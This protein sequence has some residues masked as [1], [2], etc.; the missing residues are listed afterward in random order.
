MSRSQSVAADVSDRAKPVSRSRKSAAK[1]DQIIQAAIVII[2]K[3]SYALATMAEIA[4]ALDLQDAALYHYFPSKRSLAYACHRHSLQRFERIL[5]EADA[6]DENGLGK[7]R[8]F[9]HGFL[10]DS[11]RH[12][13]QLYFGDYSYLDATQRR[14]IA[15]WAERLKRALEAFLEEGMA[16]G[17]ISPCESQLV[18]QFIVG[19]LIWMGKWVPDVEGVTVERL[20]NAIQAFAFSGLDAH[21]PSSKKRL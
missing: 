15:G 21:V 16:D 9:I 14:A 18:V 4:A 13:P 12:G 6:T 11:A 3:K 17:S 19:M 8:H 2:N 1:R 7:L 5:R 10:A 20:M